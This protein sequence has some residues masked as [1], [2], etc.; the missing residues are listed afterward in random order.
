MPDFGLMPYEKYK[1]E[2]GLF[3]LEKLLND[4]NVYLSHHMHEGIKRLEVINLPNG[5]VYYA[6]PVGSLRE[7]S[8]EKVLSKMYQLLGFLSPETTIAEYKG[9]LYALTNDVL[10]SHNTE[11]G[12]I[13]LRTLC[14]GGEQYV[15]PSIYTMGEK[16][17]YYKAFKSPILKQIPTIYG[18]ALGS[19]NWDMNYCNLN[20]RFENK[21]HEQ[22]L[23][24]VLIDFGK[25]HDNGEGMLSIKYTTPFDH[26]RVSMYELY[27]QFVDA[28]RTAPELVD[29]KNI[30]SEMYRGIDSIN[31]IVEES[32]NDGFVPDAEYVENLKRTM[33][34]TARAFERE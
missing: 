3:D 23:G 15:L 9:T 1:K 21:V 27:R 13:F 11:R 22:A 18:I 31:S 4:P 10:P 12:Y 17:R 2:N 28:S 16:S 14:P 30:S 5:M 29:L 25:S 33:D 26:K 19:R 8:A 32:K 20:F 7:A 34:E 24:L 6:K